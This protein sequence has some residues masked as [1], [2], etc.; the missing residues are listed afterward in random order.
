MTT[1]ATPPAKNQKNQL[2]ESDIASKMFLR[3]SSN[4]HTHTLLSTFMYL[5]AVSPAN[6]SAVLYTDV[7]AWYPEK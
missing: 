6:P 1:L 5:F 2:V 3:I 4:R 7:A